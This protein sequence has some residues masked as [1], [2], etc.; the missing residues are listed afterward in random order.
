MDIVHEAISS[1]MNDLKHNGILFQQVVQ[2]VWS[3]VLYLFF[4]FMSTVDR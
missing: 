1:H 4:G 2:Q 3:L